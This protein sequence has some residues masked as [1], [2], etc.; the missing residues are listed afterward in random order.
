MPS[1]LMEATMMRKMLIVDHSRC[2][3]CR[4]CELVCSV[5]KGG[6]AN[7]AAARI[8]VVKWE[9]I[10]VDTPMVCQ[11][12]DT[13]PCAT[14]CP[15]QA[16][17]RDEELGRVTINYERCIGCRFCIA[18]CPFGAM[19]FDPVTRKVIK[20]DLCDGDPVCV[21]FC[22]PRAIQ[23]VDASAANAA[24]SRQAAEKLA[25]LMKRVAVATS[26]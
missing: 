6:A 1:G 21:K 2:T 18:V 12:C 15:V 8:T 13:A 10:C 14:V 22:E 20:C 5:N 25:D 11:Q 3:G 17:S 24:K 4:L 19:G 26:A 7:P 16:L 9:P 23:Y